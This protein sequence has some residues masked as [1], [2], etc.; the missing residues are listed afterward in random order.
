MKKKNGTVE[1]I[2]CR[3]QETTDIS[4][5]KGRS[6]SILTVKAKVDT[7]VR[8]SKISKTDGFKPDGPGGILGPPEKIGP[9]F[10]RDEG[11]SE[12][13]AG[14]GGQ[15]HKKK[16]TRPYSLRRR[17][18]TGSGNSFRGRSQEKMP[19]SLSVLGRQ[20]AEGEW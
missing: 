13:H 9:A 6:L 12:G 20:Q 16:K 17:G 19:V 11:N 15:R 8:K 7:P 14:E 18:G 10:C 2:P 3:Y 4:V 1:P 5:G